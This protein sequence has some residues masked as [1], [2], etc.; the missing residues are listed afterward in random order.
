MTAFLV[1]DL[2]TY[3]SVS[4]PLGRNPAAAEPEA[5]PTWRD[6]YALADINAGDLA[7]YEPTQSCVLHGTIVGDAICTP[8][9]AI[10]QQYVRSRLFHLRVSVRSDEY[11]RSCE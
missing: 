7:L 5:E 9:L 1:A 10:H 4:P 8:Y 11:R 2:S 6:W 3:C